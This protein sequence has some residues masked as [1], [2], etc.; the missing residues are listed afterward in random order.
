MYIQKTILS[1]IKL[2][3]YVTNVQLVYT[4]HSFKQQ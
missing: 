2:N 1:E 3:K 4:I